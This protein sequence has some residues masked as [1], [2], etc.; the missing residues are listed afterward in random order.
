MEFYLY[1]PYFL[2]DLGEIGP[3]ISPLSAVGFMK[4]CEVKAVCYSMM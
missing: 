3:R 2:T 4:V 1:I